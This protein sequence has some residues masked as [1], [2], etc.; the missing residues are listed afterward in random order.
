MDPTIFAAWL[1]KQGYAVICADNTYWYSAG[2]RILQSF[3]YHACIQPTGRA[4]EQL[5]GRTGNIALRYSTNID[6]AAGQ[7]S[8][9]VMYEKSSLAYSDLPKKARHD[10]RDGLEYAHIEPISFTRLASDGWT[11]RAETL[12]RQ[13]RTGAETREEW[14]HLCLSAQGLPGFEA[15]GA[16]HE[17][18]LVAAI[19][20]FIMDNCA[21][22]L[23]QQSATAHLRYGINNALAYV[24]TNEALC[25]PGINRIFYG[26]HS[27]DAP[28]SVDEFKFR[29]GYTAHPVRQR[30]VFHP[31][32]APLANP[33]SHRMVKALLARRPGNRFLAKTE[34]MLRFYLQ[35]QR[36]L[37]RQDW[38][39]NLR[40]QKERILT[41]QAI[42]DARPTRPSIAEQ[43]P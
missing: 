17:G 34:G 41:A 25:R 9:H 4:V 24:F 36:P 11:L 6:Q 13:G 40:D 3:P 30:V 12:E 23:Y 10:V 5:L 20:V 28:A 35:G 21:S 38:P 39:Q 16:L 1:Q 29:M 14:Q 27:L 15:W 42:K 43:I 7:V 22:I 31:L 8:Y 33:L 26:L 2:F 19:F 32:A 37:D 18:Q